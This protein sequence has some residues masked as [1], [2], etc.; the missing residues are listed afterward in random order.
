MPFPAYTVPIEGIQYSSTTFSKLTVKQEHPYPDQLIQSTFDITI[1]NIG[2]GSLVDFEIQKAYYLDENGQKENL[3]V[4]FTKNFILG[5]QETIRM[6]IDLSASLKL[7]AEN[8][9]T[10]LDILTIVASFADLL[11]HNYSQ[12]FTIY[13]EMQSVGHQNIST[14]DGKNKTAVIYAFNPKKINHAHPKEI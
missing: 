5:K 3:A 11:G 4:S 8:S 9:Q 12:E 14:A 7:E 2:L 1:K 6:E 10:N 13:S